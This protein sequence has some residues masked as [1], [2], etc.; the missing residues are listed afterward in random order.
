MKNHEKKFKPVEMATN[1]VTFFSMLRS[2]AKSIG[3]HYAMVGIQG[4]EPF[5]IMSSIAMKRPEC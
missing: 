1:E 4:E 2:N 3:T 5:N